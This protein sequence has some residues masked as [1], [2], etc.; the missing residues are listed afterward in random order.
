MSWVTFLVTMALVLIVTALYSV[1]Q[2]ERF[3]RDF[4][5]EVR[6]VSEEASMV[7]QD[8]EAAMENAL[9]VSQHMVAELE[10]RLQRLQSQPAE[11]AA[12]PDPGP[13][14]GGEGTGGRPALPFDREALRQA[15]PY[16][17]VPRLHAQGFT[18]PEIAE[19]LG[20]GQGEVKLILNLWRKREAAG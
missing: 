19:V 14:A 16:L 10:E 20:R 5:R 13:S 17:V 4:T 1:R 7:R 15:H 8:L 3:I 12:A 11:P 9:L 18:I 2:Q 6:E